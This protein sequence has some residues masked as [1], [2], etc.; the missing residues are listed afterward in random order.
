MPRKAKYFSRQTGTD[1]LKNKKRRRS[2]ANSAY[3]QKR[4]AGGDA[5]DDDTPGPSTGP[6]SASCTAFDSDEDIMQCDDV[7]SDAG[8][9]PPDTAEDI[10]GADI[11][12]PCDGPV[13]NSSSDDSDS[14]VEDMHGNDCVTVPDLVSCEK[15]V[16]AEEI[17][18]TCFEHALEFNDTEASINVWLAFFRDRLMFSGVRKDAR[19]ILNRGAREIP[20]ETAEFSYF[21]IKRGL[22]EVLQLTGACTGPDTIWLTVN[23][24]GLP[25]AQSIK[26]QFWPVLFYSSLSDMHV[27]VAGIWC[28]TRHPT[29]EETLKDFVD[30]YNQMFTDGGFKYPDGKI[31]KVRIRCFVCD[32]PATAMIKCAKQHSG[33]ESCIKCTVHGIYLK[34]EHTLAHLRAENEKVYLRT[35]AGFRARNE[36]TPRMLGSSKKKTGCTNADRT[37]PRSR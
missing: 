7:P 33:F 30:D 35:D 32:C 10:T 8:A 18:K 23:V 26:I 14:P 1:S 21:G 15:P 34:E 9:I 31:A 29:A 37:S 25:M 20:I 2:L 13:I 36:G 5:A 12:D 19:T 16:T 22:E 6:P 17:M 27:S 3:Y 28:G 4:T 24:D 11:P